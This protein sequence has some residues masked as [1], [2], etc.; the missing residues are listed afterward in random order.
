MGCPV[1]PIQRP[2]A[3]QSQHQPSTALSSKHNCQGFPQRWDRGALRRGREGS[4]LAAGALGPGNAAAA[5]AEAGL[6]RRCQ[7]HGACPLQC[8]GAAGALQPDCKMPEKQTPCHAN[9]SL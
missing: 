7:S 4:V 3:L 2:L 9:T 8:R 6:E 1:V 5:A